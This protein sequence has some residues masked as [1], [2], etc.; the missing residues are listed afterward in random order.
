ME[1]N[2]QNDL[3][4]HQIQFAPIIWDGTLFRQEFAPSEGAKFLPIR[5][6]SQLVE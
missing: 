2:G 3:H 6:P 4:L 1:W 5:V